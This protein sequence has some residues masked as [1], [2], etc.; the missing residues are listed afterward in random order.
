MALGESTYGKPR[1][2]G[3]LNLH[4]WAG[5]ESM[6]WRHGGRYLAGPRGGGADSCIRPIVEC[7]DLWKKSTADGV[8]FTG[9]GSESDMVSP[10][11][12]QQPGME[13]IRNTSGSGTYQ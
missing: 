10:F 11:W 9:P 7:V 13:Q 3:L 4:P 2:E 12:L 5:I 1:T 8:Q 6:E